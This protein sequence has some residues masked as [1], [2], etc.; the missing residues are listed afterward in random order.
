MRRWRGGRMENVPA[1]SFYPV[2]PLFFALSINHHYRIENSYSTPHTRR[3]NKVI[4]HDLPK[5]LFYFL[6]RFPRPAQRHTSQ[7][8]YQDA[9]P[10]HPTTHLSIFFQQHKKSSSHFI[11]KKC[12]FFFSICQVSTYGVSRFSRME[13]NLFFLSMFSIHPLTK[14]ALATMHALPVFAFFFCRIGNY[15]RGSILIILPLLVF[16][17]FEQGMLEDIT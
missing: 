7:H 9:A 8:S 11:A 3:R 12:V 6:L 5:P 2:H 16:N 4:G 17:A 1:K 13:T 14:T 10:D 15:G